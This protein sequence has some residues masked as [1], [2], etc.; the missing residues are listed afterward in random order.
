M[1]AAPPSVMQ[2][3]QMPPLLPNF[4]STSSMPPQQPFYG[5]QQQQ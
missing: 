4:V 2:A 1:Y 5:D 3:V